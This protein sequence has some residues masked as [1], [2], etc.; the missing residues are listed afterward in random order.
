MQK[1][2]AGVLFRNAGVHDYEKPGPSRAFCGFQVRDTFLHPDGARPHSDRRLDNSRDE[3]RAAKNVHDV[4]AFGNVF[5]PSVTFL[6]EHFR[7]VRIDGDDPIQDLQYAASGALESEAFK[8]GLVRAES[9]MLVVFI[10]GVFIERGRRNQIR[11][12]ACVNETP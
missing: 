6:S 11:Q 2:H 4:H 5:Q 12:T 1:H 9:V 10:I 8:G 3:F 7:F